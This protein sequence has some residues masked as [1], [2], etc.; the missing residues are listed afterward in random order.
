MTGWRVGYAMGPT[1]LVKAM[2]TVQSQSCTSI[3]SIAQ[4][5]TA[6]ALNGPQDH[7]AEF[8]AAFERRRNLV[9]EAARSID[10]LALA[11]PQGAFYAY[12]N[13]AGLIGRTTPEGERLDDDAAVVRHLLEPRMCPARPAQRM[14][15]RRFSGFRPRRAT[16]F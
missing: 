16:T 2:N 13:C 11:P 3:C 6:A 4:A 9:V 10:G 1:R 8:R 14:A 15:F 5:A 12:V 7:V